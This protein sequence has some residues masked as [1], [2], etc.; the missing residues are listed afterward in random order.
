[1]TREDP[2]TSARDGAPRRGRAVASTPLTRGSGL[3]LDPPCPPFLRGGKPLDPPLA[4]GGHGGVGRTLRKRERSS[5]DRAAGTGP[6][7]TCCR[8]SM[9]IP[10]ASPARSCSGDAAVVGARSA[11]APTAPRSTRWRVR[12]VEIGVGRA[13]AGGPGGWSSWVE[14]PDSGIASRLRVAR[15]RLTL[16]R[17]HA[18]S[19][20]D[21]T[22]FFRNP[23]STEIGPL[24]HGAGFDD[25]E[26]ESGATGGGRWPACCGIARALDPGVT[27]RYK[28]V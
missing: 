15:D 16:A 7:G 25:S 6:R 23:Q 11:K 8:P 1:M 13:A 20:A 10:A 9:G 12:G 21:P 3:I 4:K 19:G 5:R 24:R 2:A 27:T 18:L 22:R 26:D 17:Y 14:P 28:D